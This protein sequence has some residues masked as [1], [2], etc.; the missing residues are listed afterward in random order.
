MKQIQ[1]AVLKSG[2]VAAGFWEELERVWR[3]TGFYLELEV[4]EQMSGSVNT[5]RGKVVY[6]AFNPVSGL[7]STLDIPKDRI[8]GFQTLPAGVE[9]NMQYMLDAEVRNAER[10]RSLLARQ[11]PGRTGISPEDW[12]ASIAQHVAKHG[13]LPQGEHAAKDHLLTSGTFKVVPTSPYREE[14]D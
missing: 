5:S 11:I 8:E 10:K 6:K 2:K 12:L 1:C 3:V 14:Q 7:V 13:V 4:T 9:H